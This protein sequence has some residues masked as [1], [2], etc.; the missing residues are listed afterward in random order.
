M[1]TK[2]HENAPGEIW[3]EQRIKF[4]GRRTARPG[5]TTMAQG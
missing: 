2:L 4:A 5:V 1:L 3:E